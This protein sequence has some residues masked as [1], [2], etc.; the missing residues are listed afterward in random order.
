MQEQTPR[1]SN[2]VKKGA[3][4]QLSTS[5][6]WKMPP[7]HPRCDGVDEPNGN[8][9][10]HD[11]AT[12]S[13]QQQ[14][15]TLDKGEQQ[16][17]PIP[18]ENP[19]VDDQQLAQMVATNVGVGHATSEAE[20]IPVEGAIAADG[21]LVTQADYLRHIIELNRRIIT[22][23]AQ[24]ERSQIVRM[25]LGEERQRTDRQVEA[26]RQQDEATQF[27]S[28]LHVAV[29][30]HQSIVNNV[31]PNTALPVYSQP[32][33][34]FATMPVYSQLYS[35]IAVPVA[36]TTHTSTG[37]P[38]TQAYTAN[39]PNVL[40]PAACGVPATTAYSQQPMW[41]T[42]QAYI[43]P[44]SLRGPIVTSAVGPP[45][46]HPA[47]IFVST[48]SVP[49]TG[50][51]VM[52][53]SYE[54]TRREP[55]IDAANAAPGAIYGNN[56]AY[57]DRETPRSQP[58]QRR[59]GEHRRLHDLPTFSGSPEEWPMF[60]GAYSSTTFEFGYTDLENLIR[61]QKCLTGDARRSVQSLLIHP[62]HVL[63]AMATLRNLF[64]RPDDLVRSQIRQAR[65][66]PVVTEEHIEQL[67]AFATNVQNMKTFLD[68]DA[69]HHHLANPTLLDE[70]V[71]KLPMNR[72]IEWAEVA[73]R[74][75]PRPTITEF[76]QWLSEKARIIS[77]VA[78]LGGQSGRR[79]M[80]K[81]RHVLLTGDVSVNEQCAVC[82]GNH[83]V[84]D[85]SEFEQLSVKER[86]QVVFK[87]GLC[88]SCLRD[89]HI[90][91]ACN[92]KRR[93]EIAGCKMWHNAKLH[94]NGKGDR[95]LKKKAY[96]NNNRQMQPSGSQTQ[97]SL[98]G[99]DVKNEATRDV[100]PPR[101]V[102][103]LRRRQ[104]SGTLLFRVL[105]VVLNGRHR[106]IETYALLDEGASVT[107]I[108][109]DMAAQ[110]QLDG[111]TEEI[112]L[113]W[114]GE[115]SSSTL[116]NSRRVDLSISG[117]QQGA[118]QF[119]LTDVR[120]VRGL[121]LP[122]QSV[123]MA[124]LSDSWPHLNGL[125]VANYT[126]AKPTI[127]IG[128]DHHHLGVPI[129]IRASNEH[130]GIVAAGVAGIRKRWACTENPTGRAVCQGRS[131]RAIRS[132]ERAGAE[133]FF[134]GR[135]RRAAA[136]GDDRIQRRKASKADHVR[137]NEARGR[138]VRDRFVVAF[139]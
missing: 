70:L 21:N 92:N 96:N 97:Q 103:Y 121:S 123:N 5:I 119:D 35:G 85:C 108:D 34:N 114:F 20:A 6:S 47:P 139:G 74:I 62:C 50:G 128:L 41:R 78:P 104:P 16:L 60:E 28:E 44:S 23:Q 57:Y 110:L 29:T 107:L 58:D 7:T 117:Q 61:L 84:D 91:P 59:R 120:T 109:E 127:M 9:D 30:S 136:R 8:I 131:R 82:G 51:V 42:S 124:E 64:G 83:G 3:R 48:Q 80:P 134:D 39:H 54:S 126:D 93:C 2:R 138:S 13:A 67:T 37:I 132:S 32:Q 10:Q 66:L 45:M 33:S 38:T 18:E 43:H 122:M 105:P 115:R 72:R 95:Q 129:S 68:T 46:A 125:P 55:H 63:Q 36:T 75:Q 24:V 31:V 90:L 89:D 86:L 113:Q 106:S 112:S 116:S 1:R 65:Q 14:G 98:R 99:N 137:D 12:T 69:S 52:G 87:I 118:E 17:A 56:N 133:S 49:S 102:L 135:F 111:P 79:M 40:Y 53:E 130:R 15:Q 11:G 26:L 81:P 94:E 71:G 73:D 19:V 25:T 100:A 88:L 22:R 4:E 101:T 76:A 27:R 77:L